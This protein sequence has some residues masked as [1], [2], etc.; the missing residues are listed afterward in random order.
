MIV[1]W[2]SDG[3]VTYCIY[4]GTSIPFAFGTIFTWYLIENVFL[5]H[6]GSFLLI[7]KWSK[8]CYRSLAWKNKCH[9][10]RFERTLESIC[11]KTE[12]WGCWKH[13]CNPPDIDRSRRM[14]NSSCKFPWFSSYADICLCRQNGT[15]RPSFLCSFS[16]YQRSDSHV[17][18]VSVSQWDCS[19]GTFCGYLVFPCGFLCS[20]WAGVTPDSSF[21]PSCLW[22]RSEIHGT[23]CSNPVQSSNSINHRRYGQL[24]DNEK[25]RNRKWL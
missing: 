7:K 13:V 12:A 20:C 5:V 6:S 14:E 9:M 3:I 4:H 15:E 25:C 23:F 21:F 16:T 10:F 8:Q 22:G 18:S 17:W 2:F 24:D 11:N 1:A 19:S